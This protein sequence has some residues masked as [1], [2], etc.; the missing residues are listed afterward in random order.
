MFS[1]ARTPIYKGSKTTYADWCE[2]NGFQWA[3]KLI[4]REWIEE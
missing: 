1:R 3:E 2:K 4:P